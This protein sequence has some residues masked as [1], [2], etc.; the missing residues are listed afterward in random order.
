M[1]IRRMAVLLVA[2][3]FVAACA[4]TPEPSPEATAGI[5]APPPSATAE[6]AQPAETQAPRP[7]ATATAVASPAASPTAQPSPG[8]AAAAAE[9]SPWPVLLREVDF[10]VPAGNSYGPRWLALDAGQGRLYAR[11]YHTA[12]PNTGLVTMLD[13]HSGEVLAV[14]ETGPDSYAEGQLLLDPERGLLYAVNAGDDTCS[15]LDAGSLEPVALLEGVERLALD[16]EGEGLYLA[17]N[18]AL[19][20]AGAAGRETRREVRVGTSP[21]FL[22]AALDAPGSRLYLAYNDGGR[23][24]LGIHE[25]PS[26][27]EVASLTLPGRPDDLAVDGQRGRLY[28]TLD[29]GRQSLLLTLDRGGQTLDER[30]LGE[31]T[32][33]VSLA[34]DAGGGRLFLGREGYRRNAIVVLDLESG[35]ETAEIP[36]EAAPNVLAW[37]PAGRR[38]L[39]SHTYVDQIGVVDVARGEKAATWPTAINVSDLAADPARGLYFVT[40]TA[41]RL[42]VLDAGDDQELAVLPGAGRIAVDSSHGRLYT[43][44]LEAST[45]RIYDLLPAG[46]TPP[47]AEGG[48]IPMRAVPVADEYHGSLLLVQNGIHLA[49]LESLTVTA[50]ISDTLPD[51]AGYSPNPAAVDAAVDPGSGRIYAIV[52]NGIPGS[53]NGN[54]L[55]V[56]EPETYRRI[57]TDTERSVSYVAIDAQ[58]SRAYVSR[59]HLAGQST[60]LLADGRRYEAR[61]DAA[62]GTLQLDPD[63]G[64]LYLALSGDDEGQLLVLDAAN[65][66]VLGSVPI[67]GRFTIRA[68]DAERRLLYLTS[69]DGRVQVWSATGGRLPEPVS[70]SPAALPVPEAWQFFAGPGDTPLFAASLYRSDDEGRR[71]AFLGEGLPDWGVA[72]VV[73]SPEFQ[74]DRTLFVVPTA[75]DRGL[76]VWKSADAGRSWRMASR[77][78]S[79]LAVQELAISP[80]F[81]QDGTLLA[82]TR[83]QGL[84]RSTDGGERWER[85]AER[86]ETPSRYAGTAGMVAFSPTYG[87]DRTIFLVHGGL[88]RS[89]DGGE[90]WTSLPGLEPASLALSPDFAHDGTMFGWFGRAGLLRSVD[91]G[92]TWQPAVKGLYLR[93]YGSARLVIAPD[94][95]E[96]KTVYLWWVPSSP[97]EERQLFRSLDGGETWQQVAGPAPTAATDARLSAD[98]S[99]FLA[100]DSDGRLV[101]WP[102]DELAWQ[103]GRLPAL[104]EIELYRLTAS[105]GF[106]QDRT[107]FAFGEGVGVLRSRDAGLTWEDTG[108]PLRVTLGDPPAL[109]VLDPDR[110]L[111]GTALGLYR[112][113]GRGWRPANG[114]LPPQSALSP[115]SGPDG[116]LRLIVQ[117]EARAEEEGPAVWISADGGGSWRQ[118]VRPAPRPAAPDDLVLSPAVAGDGTA[119]LASAWEEPLRTRQGGPWEPLPLPPGGHLT[120]LDI[121]PAFGDDGLL[122]LR[123][124]DNRLWRSRDGGD[125]WTPVDG[126]WGSG[127]AR[128]VAPTGSYRLSAVTFSPAYAQDRTLLLEAGNALYRSTD[129][130]STWQ[131]VLEPGP[132]TFRATFSPDYARDGVILIQQG[133]SIYRSADRGAS[134]QQLP[135][136]PWRAA[137]EVGLQ[138]SPTF[139]RD[140]T[141][142]A[143]GLPGLIYGSTDG[144]QSWQDLRGGLPTDVGGIRQAVFSPAYGEDGLLFLVPYG[145]GLHKRGPLGPWVPA[146]E[147][148]PQPP[149]ATA[150]VPPTPAPTSA[151]TPSATPC[152]VEPVQFRPAWQQ[153]AGRLGCPAGQA[154]QRMLAQQPFEQGTM[155]WDS[156]HK[157]FL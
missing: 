80:A 89:T 98:G 28:L 22:L 141:A 39:A 57:L 4:G 83:K 150:Q 138:L 74:Q 19:R 145:G 71:W 11:T 119:F 127:V 73:V 102:V 65:L 61:L 23:Y 10:R 24:V 32:E 76:G 142:L 148:L 105:P 59:T 139:A 40:D 126:P 107:L 114:D 52:N 99:A 16:A 149:P 21:R 125:T 68:A 109:T 72:R 155:I 130:G 143:W 81:G 53:N 56:Y 36:L 136:A 47:L 54:Y 116:S 123:T 38:L 120:S 101:R 104:E 112:F 152:P 110:V 115:T 88:K 5:G 45:V 51:P 86:Y 26:L 14:A 33:N 147:A 46:S 67:P 92:E 85:L 41:G 82:L 96:G 153:A 129:A 154:E 94:Y 50:S 78:L 103:P 58:G 106:Q 111:A 69:H 8:P 27:A 3:L 60:S 34:L 137:D 31:W 131:K 132:L 42:H 63:L 90:T 157:G 13:A 75:T 12:Q 7:A 93:G 84:F 62:F 64:R 30:A 17:G 121:S 15:V 128:A 2:L 49:S 79:D 124:E 100:L 43:G 140:R 87:Q 122:F 70:P 133:N 66:D 156:G 77:G 146:G 144:G 9:E 37:D 108:F 25:T 91:G 134:W 95:P 48:E 44:G 118:A 1:L 151:P 29:D 55:Y 18:G 97:D 20:L 117:D 135:A 113:D 6:G 35:E